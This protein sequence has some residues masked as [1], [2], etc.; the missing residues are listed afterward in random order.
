M[1]E[2]KHYLRFDAM[3]MLEQEQDE[4][5]SSNEPSQEEVLLNPLLWWKVSI[6]F[7]FYVVPDTKYCC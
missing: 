1:D 3:P 2:L 6:Q 7:L 5:T 4:K